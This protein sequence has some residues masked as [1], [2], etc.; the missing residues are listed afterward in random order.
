MIEED[1]DLQLLPEFTDTAGVYVEFNIQEK[2]AGS[3]E[4]QTKSLQSAVGAPYMTR[5][6]ARARMNLPS[7]PGGDV[8]VTPLNV[9]V[10][11][12]ASPRD[13]MPDARARS[14][15]YGT[16]ALDT[17]NRELRERHE[18]KWREV[19]ARH[20]RRQEAAIMSRVP[21]T[22]GKTDIGGI[23]WD[24][25]RW[26]RE[27]YEDLLPLNV[28]TATTWAEMAAGSLEAEVD[29]NRMMPWLEEH[30]RTQAEYINASTRNQL[31]AALRDPDP[32]EAV[33]NLFSAALTVWV[34]RQAL[35]AVTTAMSFGSTEG[36]QAGGMTQKTW[37]V[38][39]SNPR[40]S[41]A[42]LDGVTVGIRERFPN[43]L[44]WPGD[45]AGTADDNAGCQCSV[46]FS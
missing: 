37:Q 8:L 13:S 38:N 36:A 9:L 14:T 43:G 22:P 30:S 27:L 32:R 2:L 15:T 46:R 7:V 3:F 21:E 33:A 12:Q 29:Q 34:L 41:H 28:L 17:Y 16:K 39:S 44:R 1:I 26:N 6:E 20:Y 42:A 31:E 24:E 23:W 11:G 18:R 5:N 4:D 25:E 35:D 19:L 40:D 45:P 10:G